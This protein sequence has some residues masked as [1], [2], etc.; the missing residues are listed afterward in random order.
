MVNTLYETNDIVIANF[1]VVDFGAVGDGVTDDT[2]SFLNAL[3]A[4]KGDGGGVIFVPSGQYKITENLQIPTG[5][6]LRGDWKSPD[7]AAGVVGTVI[8]VYPNKGVEDAHSFLS[9]EQS[10]GITNLSIWYPEQDYNNVVAYPWTLEQLSLDNAT[11]ENVTLG[12]CL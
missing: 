11:I 5:V 10:S 4:A 8:K 7:L 9:L 1:N 3:A 12:E 6:T 2:E